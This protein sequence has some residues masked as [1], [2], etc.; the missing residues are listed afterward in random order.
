MKKKYNFHLI[1]GMA[2]SFGFTVLFFGRAIF[3]FTVGHYFS[4]VEAAIPAAVFF[5]VFMFY[6]KAMIK[7]ER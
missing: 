6:T 3:H 7:R 1:L 5:Y 4:A 2:L